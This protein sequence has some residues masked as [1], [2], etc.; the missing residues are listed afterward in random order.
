MWWDITF[1]TT[2]FSNGETVSFSNVLSQ[3]ESITSLGKLIRAQEINFINDTLKRTIKPFS[4]EDSFSLSPFYLSTEKTLEAFYAEKDLNKN[5]ADIK[6]VFNSIIYNEIKESVE[7]EEGNNDS[8]AVKF[9]F[10]GKSFYEKIKNLIPS[11]R[12]GKI[13]CSLQVIITNLFGQ[14]FSNSYPLILDYDEPIDV[15]NFSISKGVYGSNSFNFSNGDRICEGI[16]LNFEPLISIYN[17]NS[18]DYMIQIKRGSGNFT[19]YLNDWQT[20]ETQN[21][22]VGHKSPMSIKLS[23]TT[24]VVQEIS[25]GEN[26]VFRLLIRVIN[27]TFIFDSQSY[28]R[29]KYMPSEISFIK[30]EYSKGTG[31]S[32]VYKI[33]EGYETLSSPLPEVKKYTL[34]G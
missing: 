2:S 8:V 10:S 27:Q 6:L 32:L 4:S 17:G 11:S 26:C 30:G 13:S 34:L 20:I 15:S 9:N 7:W 31:Y 29:I 12:S 25:S 16:K 33:T 21:L 23:I 1:N 5:G 14:K 22:V 19:D 18:F 28:E 24:P 3:E